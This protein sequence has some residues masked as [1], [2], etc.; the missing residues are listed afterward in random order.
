M[1]LRRHGFIAFIL[2]TVIVCAALLPLLPVTAAPRRHPVRTI[3]ALV[4]LADFT[5]LA[6]FLFFTSPSTEQSVL[7]SKSLFELNCS[8]LC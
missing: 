3:A 8:R 2:L 4:S 7:V 5:F 1:T 6:I